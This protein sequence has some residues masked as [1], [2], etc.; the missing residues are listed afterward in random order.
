[1][2]AN[3]NSGALVTVQGTGGTPSY[4]YAFVADGVTPIATDY[5]ASNNA[6]LAVTLPSPNNYDVWVKDAND[7][8]FK[9]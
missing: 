1:M 7:C 9:F 5:T 2:N 3:C 8:T 4:T 6:T